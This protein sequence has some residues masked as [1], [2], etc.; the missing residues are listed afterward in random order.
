M[1]QTR[2]TY[3][4]LSHRLDALIRGRLWLQVILSLIFG[5]SF[6]LVLGP[7]LA[8]I[9]RETAELIGKWVALPGKLFLAAI[10]MVI[11]PLAASSIILGIAGTGSSDALKSIGRKLLLFIL[12]TTVAASAIGLAL[13]RMVRPG[14]AGGAGGVAVEPPAAPRLPFVTSDAPEPSS[15]FQDMTRDIP[16]MITNLIP[17]NI[18]ASLLE[19]DMLAIV[20]FS[21]FVGIA[22]VIADNRE[23]TRPLVALS[24][25]MLEISMTVIRIAMRFAPLAV[26][27]LMAETMMASGVQTLMDLAVYCAIVLAGL[28][29]LLVLYLVI[30]TVFGRIGPGAF[31]KAVGPVQ[32]LAFST[33]SSAAVMPLTMK[34]AVD[35]LKTPA[36]LAGAIIPLASTVN[37]AGTA[38]YQTVAIVFLADIG[39]ASLSFGDLALVMITLTG[40][41]IGAP[42]APGASIAILSATAASFGI[43][44]AGLPLVLGVDRIL[45]MARTAV[46]VT[47]DLVLCRILAPKEDAVSVAEKPVSDV[48]SGSVSG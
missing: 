41:S 25:A 24:Q 28:L 32:L 43:P 37:M 23:L 3:R 17:Q 2:F 7:D 22:A 12:S 4:R 44:L 13:A 26:F 11:I 38:L 47:G 15:A 10:R 33:S 35:K 8:L 1:P 6:G 40:A 14:G 31:L 39:G 45:D 21:L 18:T 42:A 29:A 34:T 16:D 48:E 46:N 19:Q 5:V 27:G 20:V 36:S 30:A 9:S